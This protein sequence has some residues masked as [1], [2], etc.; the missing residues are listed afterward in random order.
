MKALVT[1]IACIVALSAAFT[2]LSIILTFD[3]IIFATDQAFRGRV[4]NEFFGAGYALAEMVILALD[5][6]HGFIAVVL[7]SI[8]DHRAPTGLHEGE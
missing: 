6:L 1:G 4:F 3:L 7:A 5:M 8:T 2:V